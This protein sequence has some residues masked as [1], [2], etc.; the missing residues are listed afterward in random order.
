MA[1]GYCPLAIG[2]RLLAIND[3]LPHNSSFPFPSRLQTLRR[4]RLRYWDAKPFGEWSPV[5]TVTVGL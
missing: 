5:A 2:Y 1:I 4:Y 3:R